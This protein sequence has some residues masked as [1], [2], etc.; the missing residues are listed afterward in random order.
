MPDQSGEP[1]RQMS[2]HEKEVNVT[3]D[4]AT[5]RK[6]N[7]LRY[8]NIVVGLVLAAQAVVIAVLTNS[9]S[10]PVTA[11]FIQGPP[12]TTPQLHHLF[13]IYTGW[14]VFAF[15]AIS[16]APSWQSRPPCSFRGTSV[17]YSRVGTTHAGSST[18]SAPPS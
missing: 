17:T 6:L 14:G 16:A 12:G 18:S 1:A 15:L 13:D 7:A 4:Q 2:E 11:T 5:E 3:V 9:F 8:W 10:L